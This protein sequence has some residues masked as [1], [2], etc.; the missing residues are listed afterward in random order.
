L[1]FAGAAGRPA[2][3]VCL[4]LLKARFQ[5]RPRATIDP[6]PARLSAIAA[7]LLAAALLPGCGGGGGGGKE[8]ADLVTVPHL[9]TGK[10]P[11]EFDN[12]VPVR[13]FLRLHVG[14]ETVDAGVV[15]TGGVGVVLANQLDN[16]ACTWPPL[17]SYLAARDARVL[18]FDYLAPDDS[19]TV[20]AA[21]RA[22]KRLGA[23]RVVFM[24][25]SL[26]G[27]VVLH[28]AAREPQVPAAVI[29]L[30]PVPG[31]ISYPTAADVKRLQAPTL[32]VSAAA[33]GRT[34]RSLYSATEAS[35]KQLLVV[36]GSL[37]GTALLVGPQ[38]RRILTTILR[39]IRAHT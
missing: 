36:G 25:S 16:S 4:C 7:A 34:A 35:G 27:P 33:E 31:S 17:P 11:P 28:A 12:C 39:F 30:S 14:N 10:G 18:V 1:A 37:H 15:G 26:G 8:P 21:G 19:A 23:R 3:W 24:G 6:V 9:H 2:G 5:R 22:L 38:K 32:Y 29:T 13:R 20:L